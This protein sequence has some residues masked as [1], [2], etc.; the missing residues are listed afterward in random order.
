MANIYLWAKSSMGTC[1]YQ[2]TS[3][4][5]LW[6]QMH[7]DTAV[8]FLCVLVHPHRLCLCSRPFSLSAVGG[9]WP[10][11]APSAPPL[12]SNRAISYSAPTDLNQ[13]G[14][15][16]CLTQ[17]NHTNIWLNQSMTMT[18]KR[19]E[20]KAEKENDV[21]AAVYSIYSSALLACTCYHYDQHDCICTQ[22]KVINSF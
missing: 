10:P 9:V 18:E 1:W 16:L 8:C 7:V 15:I 22:K 21:L 4:V 5:I 11:P 3:R 17:T 14:H 20:S 2:M 13:T 6:F 12:L 19:R